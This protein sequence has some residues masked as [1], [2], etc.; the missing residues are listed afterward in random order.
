ML[1]EKEKS[2]IQRS[3]ERIKGIK[4]LPEH[5]KNLKKLQEEIRKKRKEF[6][7]EHSWDE[8][9]KIILDFYIK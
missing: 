2:E 5:Q 4:D 3:L 6:E 1:T 9:E 8:E 7:I